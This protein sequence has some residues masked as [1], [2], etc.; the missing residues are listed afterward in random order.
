[1]EALTD[2]QFPSDTGTNWRFFTKYA[3][4]LNDFRGEQTNE[5][6]NAPALEFLSLPSRKNQLGTFPT[7]KNKT[8]TYFKMH[9]VTAIKSKGKEDGA[10]R[11]QY[12]GSN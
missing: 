3:E 2:R 6:Q 12:T 7:N 8:E 4:P 9:C 11:G 5:R 10:V 1:M